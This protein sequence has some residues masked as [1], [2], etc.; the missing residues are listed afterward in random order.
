MKK[1]LDYC[2][3]RPGDTLETIAE[4]YLGDAKLWPLLCQINNIPEDGIEPGSVLLLH[5]IGL[6]PENKNKNKKRREK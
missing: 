1:E 6:E 5:P 4:K 2:I 3:V